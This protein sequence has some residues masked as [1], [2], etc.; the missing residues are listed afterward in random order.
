M[1]FKFYTISI[2]LFIQYTGIAQT[3]TFSNDTNNFVLEVKY[4]LKQKEALND[5]YKKMAH[6]EFEFV[7]YKPSFS[8]K[9]K[10]FSYKVFKHLTKIKAFNSTV[11][12][13]MLICINE[14]FKQYKDKAIVDNWMKCVFKIMKEGNEVQFIN[15]INA[16]SKL[17]NNKTFFQT[18]FFTYKCEELKCTF[19]FDPTAKIIFPKVDITG[20]DF[21][22]N[23]L[24]I[25]DITGIYYP[26]LN[27]FYGTNGKIDWGKVGLKNE[28]EVKLKRTTIDFEKDEIFSDSAIFKGESFISKPQLGIIIDKIAKD[29][30]KVMYPNFTSYE[31]H[32]IKD[33]Y[34][35]MDYA[36]KFSM[37]GKRV[38]MAGTALNPARVFI[39]YHENKVLEVSSRNF[40]YDEGKITTNSAKLSIKLE[41]DSISH[42]DISFIYQYK[43]SLVTI[44]RKNNAV[45]KSPFFNTYH[46]LDMTFDQLTWNV[47]E[48]TMSFGFLLNNKQ[49]AALFESQNSFS[50]AKIEDIK[51]LSDVNP[52]FKINEFYLKNNKK[53]QFTSTELAKYMNGFNNDVRVFLIKMAIYGLIYFDIETE[54]I[55]IKPRFFDYIKYF[56]NQKDY[57]LITIQSK[58][59]TEDNASLNFENYDLQINGVKLILLSQLQKVFAF[60]IGQTITMKKN[61]DFNFNGTLAA[62]KFEF[63]GSNFFFE[64]NRYKITMKKVDSCSVFYESATRN[65]NNEIFFKKSSSVIQNLNSELI[66]DSINNKAGKEQ[67]KQFPIL[68][69][70]QHSFVYYEKESIYNS[71]YKKDDFY[72]KVDPFTIDSIN[73]FKLGGNTKFFGTLYSSNIYE[74]FQENLMLQKD[75]SLGFIKVMKDTTVPLYN[76]VGNFKGVLTL[77]NRGFI[78]D[79]EINYNQTFFKSNKINFFKDSA[80]TKAIQF[81]IQE[82]AELLNRTKVNG[83]SI[84]I[85]WEPYNNLLFAVTKSKLLNLYNNKCKFKGKL[86]LQGNDLYGTGTADLGS[87]FLTSNKIHLR[88]TSIYS[89]N[90]AIKVKDTEAPGK[91]IFTSEN[92]KANL[93][94]SENLGSFY[95]YGKNTKINFEKNYFKCICTKFFWKM[96][97]NVM[98]FLSDG[99]N[100]K[101]EGASDVEHLNNIQLTSTSQRKDSI[102]FF[103]DTISYDLTKYIL[104][105]Y[106]V[107]KMILSDATIFPDKK[108]VKI[109]PLGIIDTL[110]N[111]KIKTLVNN[112]E[113]DYQD[114]S[115][116]AIGVKKY[117]ATGKYIYKDEYKNDRTLYCTSIKLDTSAKT[118]SEALVNEKNPMMLND[119]FGFYGKLHLYSKSKIINADGYLQI[120]D[121]CN[122]SKDLL[123]IKDTI[124]LSKIMINVTDSSTNLQLKKITFGYKYSI[125]KGKIEPAFFRQCAPLKEKQFIAATGYLTFNKQKNIYEVLNKSSDENVNKNKTNQGKNYSSFNPISCDIKGESQ[126]NFSESFG[127]FKMQSFGDAQFNSLTQSFIMDAILMIDYFFNSDLTKIFIK[128]INANKD[129]LQTINI[130]KPFFT[131]SLNYL[132]GKES[133]KSMVDDLKLEGSVSSYPDE[134]KHNLVLGN[135]KFRFDEKS[136]SFVSLNDIDLLSVGNEQVFKSIPGYVQIVKNK[137]GDEF[138]LFL[139]LDKNVWYYFNYTNEVLNIA[140]SNDAFN[141][142][143]S[144]LKEKD[145]ELKITKKMTNQTPFQFV[146]CQQFKKELFLGKIKK[147]LNTDTN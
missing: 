84:D 80:N 99:K 96:N 79:G 132:L 71:S 69:S 23:E 49:S 138:H 145:R 120:V 61:R 11:Y 110:R 134:L 44:L 137:K 113:N 51:G 81:E 22:S 6:S 56:K 24:T 83:D 116:N 26:M 34:P 77:N 7:F 133:A 20:S 119:Y 1:K 93:D 135:I 19:E 10:E 52:L 17:F 100:K 74:P 72:F 4:F 142:S 129:K 53:N 101:E 144:I 108:F 58:T 5:N 140:S 146:S 45:Q 121:S 105:N 115:V 14:T 141:N 139:K 40:N 128:D 102:S 70:Y 59:N 114:C 43:K 9:Y 112:T 78:G 75:G 46:K 66:I 107:D 48:P 143:L 18:E 98:S 2:L 41:N 63:T 126:F 131:K 118:I 31:S 50:K 8:K 94:F 106:G 147:I 64:Y 42:P 55:I 57:D 28:A 85:H 21:Y 15:F 123:K 130:T 36:G 68:K 73:D 13:D 136:N 25:N 16:S 86:M 87:Y 122:K 88:K 37:S 97:E 29:D 91:F 30:D 117:F 76:N 27:K 111:A 67:F 95:T 47:K 124:N 35:N 32:Y 39:K 92:I 109:F 89:A 12:T 65:E 54:I 60:P 3:F 127:N 33:I 104:S 125:D 38:N 90:A 82:T 103:G 62:G